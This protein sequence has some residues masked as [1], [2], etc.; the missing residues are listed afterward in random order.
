MAKT[1]C[2]PTLKEEIIRI[3]RRIHENPELSFREFETA[4]TIKETLKGWGIPYREIGETGVYV[5]IVGAPSGRAIG[6]RADIDALPIR[7]EADVP[8]RSKRDGVMHACG[9]DG[10]TAMLL[11]ATKLL[12]ESR[13]SLSGTVR[14][15]FQ[16]GEELDGAAEALIEKGILDDPDIEAVIGM[17]LWPY[18]PFG[19]VGVKSGGM[20]ASCDDFKITV[21]GKGGHCA[22]PHL[23]LDAINVAT[24]IVQELQTATAKNISPTQPALIHIGTINGGDANNV[25]AGTVV[26]EGT[27]RALSPS[28]RTQLSKEILSVCDRMKMQRGAEIDVEFVHGAPAINNDPSMTD[29]FREVAGALLGRDAVHELEEPSM[30]ADDFGY[31][32]EKVPSLYFRLGI[33]KE[34]EAAYDLHHTKFSFDDDVL[35]YGTDLYANLASELLKRRG[36]HDYRDER[37]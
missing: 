2:T 11:G 15:I 28:V 1:I 9:H 23:A 26:M 16:P 34:G 25:I 31:F 18:L 8:Y 21:K 32:S 3:R 6:L 10:H 17:H 7:E 27:A 19:S 13:H 33:K 24:K 5:D 35:A 36:H 12:H 22:R 4:E 37:A 29:L 14:C 20:T 30:G